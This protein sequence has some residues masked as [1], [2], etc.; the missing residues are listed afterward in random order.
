MS[1]KGMSGAVSYAALLYLCFA[2]PIQLEFA[3]TVVDT[4]HYVASANHRTW[5][6]QIL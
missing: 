5:L 6:P 3:G 4:I 2:R 1:Q